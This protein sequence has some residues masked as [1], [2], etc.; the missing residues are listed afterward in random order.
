MVTDLSLSSPSPKEAPQPSESLLLSCARQVRHT[1]TGGTKEEL[2]GCPGA[3]QRTHFSKTQDSGA[4]GPAHLRPRPLS[5]LHLPPKATQHC[6]SLLAPPPSSGR[7]R[8]PPQTPP[9]SYSE[10]DPKAWVDLIPCCPSH[11]HMS[12]QSSV[13][14]R[15]WPLP[16]TLPYSPRRDP[17]C[18]RDL[19]GDAGIARA[20]KGIHAPIG[21]RVV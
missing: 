8:L 1:H 9:L 18:S 11:P 17:E 20:Q 16:T 14:A 13:P 6:G 2:L 3:S 21:R 4:G 7:P 19:T 5:Q 12:R 15:A 10:T